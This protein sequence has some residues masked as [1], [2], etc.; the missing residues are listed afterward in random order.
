MHVTSMYT[1]ACQLV[2]KLPASRP[3]AMEKCC[4]HKYT[5]RCHSVA[6]LHLQADAA[7]AARAAQL[8]ALH[9][10]KEQMTRYMQLQEV[11]V[12]EVSLHSYTT[13]V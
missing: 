13:R 4:W 12:K 2:C 10:H 1:T 8:S 6:S 7:R 3:P 9:L 11:R 5:R